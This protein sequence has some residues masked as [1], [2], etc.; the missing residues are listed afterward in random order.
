MCEVLPKHVFLC[1]R[2]II[3]SFTKNIMD[4]DEEVP[5]V[6]LSSS[7]SSAGVAESRLSS[8]SLFPYLQKKGVSADHCKVVECEL[9]HYFCISITH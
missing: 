5:N 6:S 7:D 4:E 8:K 2:E 3:L 9:H 1:C